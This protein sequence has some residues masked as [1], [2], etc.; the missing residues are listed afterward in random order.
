MLPLLSAYD[1]KLYMK[2]R[3]VVPSNQGSRVR[4]Q[5]GGSIEKNKY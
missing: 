2:L 5:T 4:F 3:L 1:F